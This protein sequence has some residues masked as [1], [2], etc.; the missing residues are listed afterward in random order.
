[1]YQIQMPL[2]AKC[3]S[4]ALRLHRHKAA[5][6]PAALTSRLTDAAPTWSD[7]N[8]NAIDVFVW[9]RVVSRHCHHFESASLNSPR[10]A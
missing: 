8:K 3:G 1:M 7:C 5:L 2:S 10:T 6:S 9:S 4:S